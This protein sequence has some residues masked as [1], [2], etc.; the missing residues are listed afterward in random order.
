MAIT[1]N[2]LDGR[3]EFH[4][5]GDPN[6]AIF[7]NTADVGILQRAKKS[8]QKIES[9]ESELKQ[10]ESRADVDE[11]TYFSM[12]EKAQQTAK[13]AL[14][15]IFA[16]DIADTVFGLLSPFAV[17]KEDGTTYFEAFVEA[18]LPVVE[19]D[20]QAL[21]KAAQ[22]SKQRTA[23]YTNKYAKNGDAT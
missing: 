4:I 3:K 21:Q 23:K 1:L 16:A 9:V 12:L 11:E 20:Q 2:V 5:N 15:D 19:R 17:V 7:I 8:L 6:R 18:I 22:Q 10:A 14:N 13:D